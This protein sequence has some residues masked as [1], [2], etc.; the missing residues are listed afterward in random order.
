M[1]TDTSAA[2]VQTEHHPAEAK[3]LG[4]DSEGWVYASLTIF[5]LVAFFVAGAHKRIAAILDDRIANTRRSLDEAKSLRDEAEA[6]L[7]EAHR[8]QAAAHAD[9]Q[10]ILAHAEVEAKQLVEKARTDADTLV[11]RRGRMAEEKIAAAERTA[12]ADVRARAA[13]A[14][15]AA[16]ARIIADRDDPNADRALVSRTIAGL[17]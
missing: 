11:E 17:S 14:A 15:A 5:L 12:V 16:A 1:A 10:A 6:L 9:A 3:L 7:A 13:Q 4:L 2:I 8:R